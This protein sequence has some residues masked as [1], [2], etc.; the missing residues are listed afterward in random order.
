MPVDTEDADLVADTH[1]E[2][3]AMICS[4]LRGTATLLKLIPHGAASCRFT[5]R[6]VLSTRSGHPESSQPAPD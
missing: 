2:I 1:I 6:P 4:Q 3:Q 5:T